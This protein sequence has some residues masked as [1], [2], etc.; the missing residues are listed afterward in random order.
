MGADILERIVAAKKEAVAASERSLPLDQVRRLAEAAGPRRPFFEAL[1]RPGAA[2]ANIIAEIKRASPSKGVLA[3]SLDPAETAR[4]YAAGGAAALSVLT[5][6]PFF[7][8]SADDLRSARAATT[9]PVLRKDFIISPYQ[10]Y[11]TRAWG[12]DALLLIVR[13][14]SL[15]QLQTLLQLSRTLNLAALVEVHSVEDL[16]IATRAGAE[17]IGIN[18]RNLATFHTDISVS[19]TLKQQFTPRQIAVAASG[20]ASPEDIKYNLEHGIFNFLIGESLVTAD[21]PAVFLKRLIGPVAAIAPGSKPQA[22]NS[23]NDAE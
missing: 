18:N 15:S 21:D 20:I 7:H 1:R 16:E 10:V 6:E 3:P 11:E 12:A 13:I 8:G 9:L 23:D 5:D 17:L 14:L 2:G 19:I 4:A 22:P